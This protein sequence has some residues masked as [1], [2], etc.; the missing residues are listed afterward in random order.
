LLH[1][2]TLAH[3]PPLSYVFAQPPRPIAEAQR[4]ISRVEEPEVVALVR[5]EVQAAMTV[6]AATL[7]FSRA[8]YA[9]IAEHVYTTLARRLLVEKERRG[10]RV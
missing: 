9:H 8:D 1:Q 2:G 3:P 7:H 10:G 4:V 5:Q 6:G